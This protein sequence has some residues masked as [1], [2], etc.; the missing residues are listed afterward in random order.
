[1]LTDGRRVLLYIIG[2][3]VDQDVGH[4]LTAGGGCSLEVVVE[5]HFYIDVHAFD[6]DLWHLGLTSFP[7]W[8]RGEHIC[9]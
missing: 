5:W 8:A 2:D 6:L 3:E 7:L 9:L 1:M 4:V